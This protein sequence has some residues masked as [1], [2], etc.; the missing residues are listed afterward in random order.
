MQRDTYIILEPPRS[1]GEERHGVYPL[2]GRDAL[3]LYG[4]KPLPFGQ[5]GIEFAQQLPLAI[6]KRLQEVRPSEDID[7][8]WKDRFAERYL[9][10]W[11]QLRYR[12]NRAGDHSSTPAHRSPH[13]DVEGTRKEPAE[14]PRPKRPRNVQAQLRSDLTTSDRAAQGR[15]ARKTEMA[16]SI[17]DWL[18]AKAEDMDEPYY[19]AAFDATRENSDASRGAVLLN[20]EHDAVVQFVQD[21]QA[22]YPPQVS[23][24]VESE[25]WSVLGQSLVAKVVHVQALS[26]HVP[27]EEVEQKFLSPMALTT[28]ALG[29]VFESEA[30]RTR[31]GGALGVKKIG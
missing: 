13:V 31:I 3:N 14:A 7:R 9:Q 15:P 23:D 10:R 21:F 17:P 4:G 29:M 1:D 5:W 2:G 18:P 19:V 12:L 11:R 8:S 22:I 27:R 28:S 26:A 24:R 20:V 6:Q 25:C 16:A 30:L